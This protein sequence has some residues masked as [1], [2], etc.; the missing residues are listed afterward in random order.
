MFGERRVNWESGLGFK[1]GLVSVEGILNVGNGRWVKYN[2]P[3]LKKD[4]PVL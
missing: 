1:F 2:Y 3:V 4:L